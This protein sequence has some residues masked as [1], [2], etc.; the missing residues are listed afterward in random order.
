MVGLHEMIMNLVFSVIL[1][2]KESLNNN[3]ILAFLGNVTERLRIKCDWS[4]V[5]YTKAVATWKDK[6]GPFL[7][8]DSFV[9]KFFDPKDGSIGPYLKLVVDDM[10]I[11]KIDPNLFQS[12]NSSMLDV[13]HKF[14]NFK[15]STVAVI[16]S[17]LTE[18]HLN[19]KGM[20]Q[21]DAFAESSLRNPQSVISNSEIV[22]RAETELE[23]DTDARR[24]TSK[25]TQLDSKTLLEENISFL[26][27]ALQTNFDKIPNVTCTHFVDDKNAWCAAKESVL[28]KNHNYNRRIL[29][30]R[31]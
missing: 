8:A 5:T 23:L 28:Y 31:I 27:Q 12:L 20:D 17:E 19:D 18:L 4:N 15:D 21:F 13:S 10:A 30:I 6:S 14:F 22:Q 16:A 11:L 1:E 2:P 26:G 3:V 29:F 9:H 24:A 7:K 25:Q